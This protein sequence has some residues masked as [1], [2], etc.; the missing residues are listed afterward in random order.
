MMTQGEFLKADGCEVVLA[1]NPDYKSRFFAVARRLLAD[2]GQVTSDL[3]IE[4]I[5]MPA[6]HPNAVGACMRAFAKANGLVV[7]NYVK[8]TR[9]SCHAAIVAVWAKPVF[10]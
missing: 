7:E 5:G 8:S 6:G 2:Q 4:A 10:E 1:H 3:V 9:P